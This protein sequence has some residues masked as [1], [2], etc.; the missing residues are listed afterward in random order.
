MDLIIII[1]KS[2]RNTKNQ[3]SHLLLP[4]HNI[5]NAKLVFKSI[6]QLFKQLKLGIGFLDSEE[7]QDW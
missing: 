1:L 2:L 6:T 5:D 4:R 7:L 3:R